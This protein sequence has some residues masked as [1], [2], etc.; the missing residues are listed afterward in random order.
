MRCEEG[1]LCD[2][3]GKDVEN[4]WESD[5]YLRYVIG[6][7]DPETL[8]TTKERHLT[9]NPPLAQFIVAAEFPPVTAGGDFD[10]NLLDPKF[11]HD[12]EELVTRG[13][14]RLKE[15]STLEGVSILDYPLTEVRERMRREAGE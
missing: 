2:V 14:R 4:I 13:W 1:Y 3:C 7:I 6:L 8:H 10:K 11:V 15:L 5:L 9:C 12:R